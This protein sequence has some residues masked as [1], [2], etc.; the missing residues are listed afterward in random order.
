MV[1]L[2]STQAQ[3]NLTGLLLFLEANREEHMLSIG[4]VT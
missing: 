3:N 4:N 2:I 1:H